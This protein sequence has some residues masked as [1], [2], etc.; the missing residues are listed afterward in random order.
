MLR[1]REHPVHLKRLTSTDSFGAIGIVM[2]TNTAPKEHRWLSLRRTLAAEPLAEAMGVS[3]VAR[4]P[5]GF[6]REYELAGTAAK[7]K[8]RPVPGYPN[9][10]WGQR[11]N[12]F[13]ARHLP[14]YRKNPTERR[15]VSL[16]LWAYFPSLQP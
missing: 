4:G 3:K 13:I 12:A 1:I 14:Q 11:R 5:N 15:R 8:K 10:T 7:M 16:E 6:M 2:P 9:Q